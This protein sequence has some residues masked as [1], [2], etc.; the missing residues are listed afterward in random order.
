MYN[1]DLGNVSKIF[2]SRVVL[3]DKVGTFVNA[4]DDGQNFNTWQIRARDIKIFHYTNM[5]D[6]MN[7][8]SGGVLQYSSLL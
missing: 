3:S 7:T 2:E 6:A 4:V 1:I 8:L 5:D